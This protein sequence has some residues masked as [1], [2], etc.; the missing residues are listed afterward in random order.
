MVFV[1]TSVL[2]FAV[3]RDHPLRSPARRFFAA[4]TADRQ[5]LATSSEVL[6]ELAHAYLP[7][8]RMQALAAA[9]RIVDRTRMEVW[10]LER[11]DVILGIDLATRHPAL[12]ARDLCH[13]ASCQRRGVTRI[14]TFD[15]A[16][17]AA[18]DSL[19]RR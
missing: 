14:Q 2:M 13:L 16:L 11:D 7:V 6:Q 19:R 9:L 12:G 1:D 18:A 4:A 17:R 10:P 8:E 15:R 5:P 3:G